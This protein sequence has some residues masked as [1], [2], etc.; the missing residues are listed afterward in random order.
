MAQSVRVD[1][2]SLPTVFHLSGIF[3]TGTGAPATT[4]R[5]SGAVAAIRRRL[6]EVGKLAC[7]LQYEV[8]AICDEA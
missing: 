1:P 2:Q 5:F 3:G 6:P 4:R 7:Q 8:I